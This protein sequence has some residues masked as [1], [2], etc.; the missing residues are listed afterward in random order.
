MLS[1]TLQKRENK[2]A[3]AKNQLTHLSNGI[4]GDGSLPTFKEKLEKTKDFPIK[5]K[6]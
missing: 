1:K 3:K 5:P 6:G 4:F 2:L